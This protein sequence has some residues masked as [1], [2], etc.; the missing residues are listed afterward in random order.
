MDRDEPRRGRLATVEAGGLR[1]GRWIRVLA[2][3]DERL[4][5]RVPQERARY[6][7]LGGVVLGTATIAAFSMW[8]AVSQLLGFSHPLIVVPVLIHNCQE[9][10]K[11][12]NGPDMAQAIVTSSAIKNAHGDPMAS[13]AL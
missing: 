4:L 1:I 12:K 6:T 10:L 8:F 2:G 13:D 7:G 9:L 5:D 11:P 3:V